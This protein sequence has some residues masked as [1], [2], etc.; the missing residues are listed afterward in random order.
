LQTKEKEVL[1][2]QTTK[3][4]LT[5]QI[6]EQ[7]EQIIK[8]EQEKKKLTSNIAQLD[9]QIAS[10]D[11]AKIEQLKQEKSRL[12]AQQ[13]NLE[14]GVKQVIQQVGTGFILSEITK[15]LSEKEIFQPQN[16]SDLYTLI[17]ALKER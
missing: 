1:A 8:Q 7:A 14:A 4:H 16:L 3:D 11:A 2:K 10:I 6:N 9:Q 12:Y 15:H 17:Q 13:E 5:K